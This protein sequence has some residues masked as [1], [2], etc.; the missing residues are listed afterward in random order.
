MPKGK[1]K[2]VVCKRCKKSFFTERKVGFPRQ[3]CDKCV[4]KIKK[5]RMLKWT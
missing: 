5:E 1:L 4:D 2:K 3:Y